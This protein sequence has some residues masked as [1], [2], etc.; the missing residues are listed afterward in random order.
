MYLIRY[1]Q[2]V[3]KL[4]TIKAKFYTT[5][6]GNAPVLDWLRSL[7]DEDKRIIGKAIAKCEFQWP[8]GPPTVKRLTKGLYEIRTDLTGSKIAR[9]FFTVGKGIMLL[10]HAIIK[11]TQKTPKAAID[12]A[13]ARMKEATND[14]K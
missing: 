10:L 9:I 13:L 2:G 7:N 6:S 11:K 8:I 5:K 4:K 14:K 3:D 12:L 1:I